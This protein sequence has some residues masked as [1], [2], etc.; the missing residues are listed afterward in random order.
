M[1][2]LTLGLA[3]HLLLSATASP[4]NAPAPPAAQEPPLF[5]E[6]ID[7][8]VVNVEAVVTDHAGNRVGDLKPGDFRLKVDGREVPI[9]FFSEIRE[10][11][12]A[13]G[14]ASEGTPPGPVSAGEPVGTSYL[15]FIDD[16]F[17]TAIRRNEVLA[18][19]KKDLS[20]LGPRDAMA[21][22]EFDGARLKRLSGWTN[23]TAELGRVF[24][25]EAARPAHG[26]ERGTE[27]RSFLGGQ[28]L[29]DLATKDGDPQG[30]LTGPSDPTDLLGG[31]MAHTGLG[32]AQRAYGETLIE[33][34][35][36]AVSAVISA[37]RGAGAPTGRKVML[38][39]SGGWPFSVQSFL[40]AG[41]APG[42]PSHEL[43]DGEEI[44]RPLTSTAN[45]LGFTLYPVDV[46]GIETGAA[47]ATSF[48]PAQAGINLRE[49]EDEGSL[50]FIAQET[51]G[52]ALL[53]SAR[54]EALTTA[55]A[56][57]SS[58]YW[59]GFTP[60][61]ER[62]DKRHKIEVTVVRPGLKVRSRNS[63]LDLSRQA[64]V[65]M[66]L[67]SALLFGGLPGAVAMPIRL[68]TLVKNDKARTV[69]IPI[70][71]GLPV[72]IL[73]VIE[74]NGK[75]RSHLELRAVAADKDGNRSGVP[76]TPVDLS[77]TKAPKPGG[78]VKYETRITLKG[79]ASHLV[80]AIYDVA[81]GKIATT[82]TDITMP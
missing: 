15:V 62:N 45:L 70:T 77:S 64:E 30:L 6:E 41:D 55:A 43:K 10:G 13:S 79:S 32:L 20:R 23:S 3:L 33:Q 40:E 9:G 1:H 11:Q 39:L 22:I 42:L 34:L 54:G 2:T 25:E 74:Q 60:T 49:Q 28:N 51:G 61:W 58:Y 35:K 36:T 56:D 82:E 71:L 31:R 7:V 53:N 50:S 59:L 81:S 26:L 17:S 21:V 19:F 37:M 68:G 46:P 14:P 44:Y 16:Y 76:V 63:F 18:A 47:D 52:R 57:V 29:G 65:S 72:S 4:Q 12:A 78:F 80:V 48:G 5:G 38:L 73:T 69:E 27:L 8:R 67:E 66:R 75:F 24:D